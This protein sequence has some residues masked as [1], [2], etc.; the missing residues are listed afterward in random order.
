MTP[1]NLFYKP[2]GT[3][4]KSQRYDYYNFVKAIQA[5]PKRRLLRMASSKRAIIVRS[6]SL[7]LT[8]KAD[9][10][11]T[12]VNTSFFRETIEGPLKSEIETPRFNSKYEEPVGNFFKTCMK[13]T[14]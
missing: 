7:S 11:K 8:T 4:N 5:I 9:E 13:D 6:G 1:E 2:D 3:P 12:K 10:Q 14:Y